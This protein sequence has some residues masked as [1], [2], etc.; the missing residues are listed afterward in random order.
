[1]KR[2]LTVV[3]ATG[4]LL[5]ACKKGD[6]GNPATPPLSASLD[7]TYKMVSAIRYTEDSL[8]YVNG[9]ISSTKYYDTAFAF[10]GTAIIAGANITASSLWYKF[11]ESSSQKIYIKAAGTTTVTNTSIVGNLAIPET[12]S[13]S[14]T[15]KS[16]DSLSTVGAPASALFFIN[17][18][19]KGSTYK[20]TFSGGLLT[21]TG[22]SYTPDTG[23]FVAPHAVRMN[24]TV[25]Y[26]KQ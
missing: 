13:G 26:Q 12:S 18:N 20:Y 3:A 2:I 24:T 15:V 22:A 17:G 16:T 23:G 14:F 25:I 1:M 11:N 21:I 19:F 9:D 7:G 6:S 8:L 4:I 5:A 10:A